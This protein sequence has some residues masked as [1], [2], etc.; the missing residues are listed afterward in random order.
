MPPWPFESTHG[1]M[2]SDL[3]IHHRNYAAHAVGWNLAWYSLMYFGQLI[4]SNDVCMA[5]DRV[6]WPTHTVRKRLTML[7]SP[8]GS[9]HGWTTSG[10]KCHHF[11][12]DNTNR[13]TTSMWYAIIAF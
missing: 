5:F 3:A 9:I 6:P 10:I 1:L 7:S 8:M 13:R 11:T 12:L 4:L 2:K